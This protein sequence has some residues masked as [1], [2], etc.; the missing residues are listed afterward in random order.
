MAWREQAMAPRLQRSE[1]KAAQSPDG[2]NVI[3][4]GAEGGAGTIA[5]P[6]MAKVLPPDVPPALDDGLS[7]LR[8]DGGILRLALRYADGDH[9]LAEDA[10]QETCWAILR[11]KDPRRIDN[12]EAYFRTVLKRTVADQ[13][14]HICR[15]PVP[16]DN[17]ET[18][19]GEG[20]SGG[21]IPGPEPPRPV[22]AQALSNVLAGAW[23]ARLRRRRRQLRALLPDSSDDP[24]R[25]RD[26][27]AATAEEID[28]SLGGGWIGELG[29]LQRRPE[30][31]LPGMVRR[32]GLQAEHRGPAA[33]PRP[34][35]RQGHAQG[36]GRP[37]RS[38]A[39]AA[40]EPRPGTAKPTARGVRTGRPKVQ[41]ASGNRSPEALTRSEGGTCSVRTV[42]ERAC[43]PPARPNRPSG[44]QPA[45]AIAIAR[46]DRPAASHF[47]R[48]TFSM[49]VPS[50]R[51]RSAFPRREHPRAWPPPCK[52]SR[53]PRL[54]VR[55]PGATPL[56]I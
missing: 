52:G 1:P 7:R 26:V 43:W 32:A 42:D 45:L 49:R 54:N 47:R 40:A 25:Y 15:A 2:H 56:I 19:T 27:V 41:L 36:R 29:G 33:Q 20:D 10:L 38:A 4:H 48:A 3:G 11:V 44:L 6:P 31:C 18:L 23:L 37:G 55:F 5:I 17:L 39:I 16:V 13:R 34:G 53:M 22:D 46:A 24:G 9:H 21:V 35:R 12:L 50:A 14:G 30:E 28:P 51:L 8:N